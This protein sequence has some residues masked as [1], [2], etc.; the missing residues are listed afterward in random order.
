MIRKI[1][2]GGQTGVEL[3]ALDI[4][5]K[6]G[7]THGGW[8]SRGKRNAEGLLPALYDLAETS[9]L[10]FQ[11]AME[12][13]VNASDGTLVISRDMKTAR[14]RTAVQAALKQQRQFLHVDLAQYSLFEAASLT[15]SWLSQQQIKVVFI[16]GLTASEDARIYQQTRQVL[17]TAFYLGFVKTGLHPEH[18]GIRPAPPGGVRDALPQSVAEAV[19]KLQSA[20][21][22]KDRTLLAN[23]Q[24]HELDHLRS[25]IGEYIKQNF[26][27]YSG[28]PQLL[29]SC[30]DAGGMTQ[31]M[32]DE[33]CAVILRALWEELRKTH[34]LRVIR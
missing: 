11:S 2:S 23:L 18:A 32:A 33:A 29:Q 17:E 7:I 13:N 34:K 1:I 15:A 10:G 4:A 22:L 14:T 21:S 9:S 8:T 24:P 27:L 20:L 30:A 6:L 26:G 16:T 3:A 19:D 5:I 25:G 12:N 31:P 28:N